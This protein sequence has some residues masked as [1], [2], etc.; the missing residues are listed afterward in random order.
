MWWYSLQLYLWSAFLVAATQEF[1]GRRDDI[2]LPYRRTKKQRN[3]APAFSVSPAPRRVDTFLWLAARITHGPV[4]HSSTSPSS[5]AA[6]ETY[7]CRT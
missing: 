1:R 3:H 6:K 5:T 4:P 7:L 2:P